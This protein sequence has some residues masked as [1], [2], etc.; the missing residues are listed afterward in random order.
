MRKLPP[1]SAV[2]AFEAAA[3][4]LNY[5]R[6]GEELGL[7]QAGVSYQ[8]KNLELHI[9]TPLFVRNGR[10]MELTMAGAALAPR[11]AQ[12]FSAMEAAFRELSEDG[13]AILTIAC[14][15]TFATKWLAP[16]L[17]SFQ[18]AHP[19]IAVRLE[20]A[21]D[22]A[23]LEAGECDLA[24]R[25]SD[26]VPDSLEAHV[27]APLELA[28]FA[29][30]GFIKTHPYLLKADPE[31]SD[32]DRISSATAWWRTWDEARCAVRDGTHNLPRGLQ[33]DSQVLDAAAAT[34]G[35]GVA[36]LS[37]ELFLTEV[38][39]GKLQRV[40]DAVAQPGAAYRLVYPP[41]RRNTEKVR[42][43]RR[44]LMREFRDSVI[45]PGPTV[46]EATG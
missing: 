45:E 44:W 29:C 30:P 17:G 24:I 46:G 26:D 23:D 22:F 20:I 31:I 25:L 39:E 34:G 13:E 5:T 37:P 9:G 21:N 33:F 41:V 35:N 15:Q 7:T 16:R 32:A 36:I 14:F 10:K 38:A 1:L 42:A 4:R 19:H 6:A 28:P 8:I 40:S 18:I 43:F 27:L 3:R 11:V 12:A 2:R